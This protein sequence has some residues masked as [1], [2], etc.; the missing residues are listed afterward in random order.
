[1][2]KPEAAISEVA[3]PDF[4]THEKEVDDLVFDLVKVLR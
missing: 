4:R 3:R 2:P 1:V